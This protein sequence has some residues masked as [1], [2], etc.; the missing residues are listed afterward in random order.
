MAALWS[1]F[2]Q[3]LWPGKCIWGALS[4]GGLRLDNQR[5]AH[6]HNKIILDKSAQKCQIHHKICWKRHIAIFWSPTLFFQEAYAAVFWTPCSSMVNL[7]IFIKTIQLSPFLD[8]TVSQS[9]S[10]VFS[11]HIY[12]ALQSLL[13][14]HLINK[15]F[16][17]S[18]HICAT[19]MNQWLFSKAYP[20]EGWRRPAWE[21]NKQRAIFRSR[22]CRPQDVN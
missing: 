9:V 18:T 21:E 16:I 11:Y 14:I 3:I 19:P 5:I 8:A 10:N 20:I 6:K 7:Q 4:A 13:I 2:E 15:H 1:Y 17:H 12:P 22:S